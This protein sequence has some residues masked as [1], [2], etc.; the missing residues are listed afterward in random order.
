MYL[1]FER[2]LAQF[3]NATVIAS[4][5]FGVFLLAKVNNPA[6]SIS[7]NILV[8]TLS[9]K[10]LYLYTQD[11]DCPIT[12]INIDILAALIIFRFKLHGLYIELSL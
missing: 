7:S 6:I 5:L 8:F 3:M 9:I 10:P 11:I 2:Q 4:T 12:Q 1:L